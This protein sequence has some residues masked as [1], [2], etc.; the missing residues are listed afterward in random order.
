M[1]KPDDDGMMMATEK[2]REKWE[3]LMASDFIMRGY[4]ELTFFQIVSQ[5][6]TK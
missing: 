1:M 3:E 6:I 2:K 5:V 4:N